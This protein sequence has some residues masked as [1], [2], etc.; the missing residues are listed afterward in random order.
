MLIAYATEEQTPLLSAE[1]NR[2]DEKGIIPY[3]LSLRSMDDESLEEYARQV[4]ADLSALKDPQHPAAIV[5]DTVQ[6]N[7][8]CDRGEKSEGKSILLG[9][10]ESLPLYYDAAD[11]NN[12]GG[13][14]ATR[15]GK[16]H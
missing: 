16:A 11:Y 8:H 14:W 7:D 5:V 6:Y 12:V 10:G 2:Q 15:H 9:E 4:G 3:Y 13:G 1:D